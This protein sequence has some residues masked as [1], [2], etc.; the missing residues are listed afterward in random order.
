MPRARIVVTGCYA[1]R[2]PDDLAS[3]PQVVRL[4]PN[5]AKPQLAASLRTAETVWGRGALTVPGCMQD[6]QGL[7]GHDGTLAPSPE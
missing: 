7:P 4:V 6:A 1:T 2:Q 3:L 5:D